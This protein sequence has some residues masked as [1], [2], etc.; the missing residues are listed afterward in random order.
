MSPAPAD[1]FRIRRDEK[2][3][4]DLE[5]EAEF[6]DKPRL[7]NR[8]L[9][10]PV[11]DAYINKRFTGDEGIGCFDTIPRYGTFHRGCS[12]GTGSIKEEA[13]ILEQ[14]P[15]LHLTF[16]DIS[17]ESLAERER[18]LGARFPKRVATERMDLN[19]VEL[20]E[21]AFD[22]V[23]SAGCIHHLENLEHVAYQINKTL[24]P[25][26]YVFLNDYVGKSRFQFRPKEKRV[27]EAAIDRARGLHPVLRNWRVAWSD[28]D[29]WEHSPF[30]AL[31][32]EETLDVFRSYLSEVSLRPGGSLVC[33]LLWLRP[34]PD[35]PVANRWRRMLSPSGLFRKRTCL[36][37][38][39][40]LVDVFRE[41]AP[42]LLWLD[43]ALTDAG[44][45]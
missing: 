14:N 44:L 26:G 34:A 1:T 20:P 28:L 19:F 6:F 45:F 30:C 43:T 31:H 32:S 18:T 7:Y 24:T 8:D 3:L 10:R 15:T 37:N 39:P 21:G 23:V 2:Y 41:V 4:R 35:R 27:F 40:S 11:V 17:A 16:Y 42:D 25:T 29:P 38:L 33:M 22:L 5:A 13:R 36:D 9:E 12:F